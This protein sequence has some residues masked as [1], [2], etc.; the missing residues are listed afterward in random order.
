VRDVAR[1]SLAVFFLSAVLAMLA[2]A[3]GITPAGILYAQWLGN[4]DHPTNWYDSALHPNT[5]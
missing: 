3:G 4:D 2:W 5:R 1:M